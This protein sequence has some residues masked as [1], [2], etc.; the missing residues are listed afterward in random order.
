MD[1]PLNENETTIFSPSNDFPMGYD[2][3]NQSG[4]HSKGI[5]NNAV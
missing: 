5:K 4:I 2:P 1:D 3:L